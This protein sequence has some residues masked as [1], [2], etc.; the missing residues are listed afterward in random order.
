[1]WRSVL[2]GKKAGTQKVKKYRWG[3]PADNPIIFETKQ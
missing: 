2:W 3:E 1:M